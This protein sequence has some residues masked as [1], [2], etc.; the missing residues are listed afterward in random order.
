MNEV[1]AR[2]AEPDALGDAQSLRIRVLYFDGCPNSEAT[3]QLV[4]RI[5]RSQRRGFVLERIEI[6]S[7]EEADDFR[8]L[9]SPTVQINGVDI[10]PAARERTDFAMVCR[11]Y[12]DSG[13]PTAEMIAAAI[14]ETA[15]GIT[16]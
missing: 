5:A 6:P 3:F 16:P 14:R 2:T 10:D 9:G 8:F 13:V 11:L 7:R 1:L 15:Q 12:G 4:R